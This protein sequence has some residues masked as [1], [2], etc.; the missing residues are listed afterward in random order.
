[1]EAGEARG[2]RWGSRRQWGWASRLPGGRE[3]AWGEAGE[4]TGKIRGRWGSESGRG[5]GQEIRGGLGWLGEREGVEGLGAEED[6]GV[7]E[8]A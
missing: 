3:R 5:L 4:I 1:M 6:A 2:W 8:G 7:K